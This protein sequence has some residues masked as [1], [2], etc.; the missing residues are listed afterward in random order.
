MGNLGSYG[1]NSWT[2]MMSG[3]NGTAGVLGWIWML[4]FWILVGLVIVALWRWITR[5]GQSTSHEHS[6]LELL[7]QR[8]VKGEIDAKEFTEKK[9]LLEE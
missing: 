6:A 7:K 8:Y 5:D 3:W 1:T 4:L 9:K 2:G